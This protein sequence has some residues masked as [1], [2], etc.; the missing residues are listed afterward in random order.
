MPGCGDAIDLLPSVTDPKLWHGKVVRV[1][2]EVTSDVLECG[3]KVVNVAGSNL[4]VYAEVCHGEC[5][6]EVSLAVL[7]AKR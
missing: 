5:D 1:V 3:G 4:I 2:H 7:T 6:S